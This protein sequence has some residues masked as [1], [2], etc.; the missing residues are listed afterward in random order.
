MAQVA[1]NEGGVSAVLKV[2]HVSKNVQ[3]DLKRR[4]R[5]L[6]NDIIMTIMTVMR[7]SHT[8]VH[9]YIHTNIIFH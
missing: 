1:T 6:S 7:M 9:T 5:N 4:G 2:A 8:D 3:G